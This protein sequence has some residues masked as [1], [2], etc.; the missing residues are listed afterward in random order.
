VTHAVIESC[1]IKAEI[2]AADERETGQRL[3]L[4]FGHTFGHAIETGTGYGTWLHGEAVAAG[5]I[6]AAGLSVQVAGL[7]PASLSRLRALVERAGLPLTAAS[8]APEAWADLMSRDKKVLGGAPRFVLLTA[9]GH[10]IV[11]EESVAREHLLRLS[12]SR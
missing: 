3:L 6:L 5:M 9:L 10:G 8:L 11:R 7:A 4:N 1:R 12:S 2:V